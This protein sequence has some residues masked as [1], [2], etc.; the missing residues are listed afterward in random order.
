MFRLSNLNSSSSSP[1]PCTIMRPTYSWPCRPRQQRP[2]RRACPREAA[3]ISRPVEA[4]A[5]AA[6]A[7]DPHQRNNRPVPINRHIILRATR[8][9]EAAITKCPT[10]ISLGEEAAGIITAAAAAT[11]VPIIKN[12]VAPPPHQRHPV[13]TVSGRRF[14]EPEDAHPI[15]DFVMLLQETRPSCR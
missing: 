9:W 11:T 7:V 10:T 13:F 1:R 5:V 12:L 4:A 6:A 15:I 8:M 3:I 2:W 14:R